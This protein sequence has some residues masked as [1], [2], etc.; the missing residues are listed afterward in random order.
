V[1]RHALAFEAA[2]AH[3]G[4]GIASSLTGLPQEQ[5]RG[6]GGW[7]A[8]GLYWQSSFCSWHGSAFSYGDYSC[9]QFDR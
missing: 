1:L 8:E 6:L 2:L 3:A 5:E 4:P 9:L 7:R